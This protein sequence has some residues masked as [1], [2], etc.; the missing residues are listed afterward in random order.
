MPWLFLAASA[1]AA[2][3][4]GA[5]AAL[6]DSVAPLGAAAAVARGVGIAAAAAGLA[7]WLFVPPPPPPLPASGRTDLLEGGKRRRRG[8][9]RFLAPLL[10]LVLLAAFATSFL[11]DEAIEWRASVERN[12]R[13]R[14][15][16]VLRFLKRHPQTG[17]L[18]EALDHLLRD[19]GYVKEAASLPAAVLE[20][21][22]DRVFARVLERVR[23]EPDVAR[24]AEAL[25]EVAALFRDPRH[26]AATRRAY[27]QLVARP[28]LAERA[29]AA[30]PGARA[31]PEGA[32][33]VLL[34]VVEMIERGEDPTLGVVTVPPAGSEDEIYEAAHALARSLAE[35]IPI[36]VRPEAREAE[37]RLA[38]RWRLRDGRL[39][40]AVKLA[41]AASGAPFEAEYEAALAPGAGRVLADA[42]EGDLLPP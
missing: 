17:R 24:A 19:P 2:A 3:L 36:E 8:G 40:V 20:A 38:L 26:V 13:G 23:D 27:V 4:Y 33:A 6:G 1:L 7:T 32:R 42:L 37:R 22:G 21:R 25:V 18:D 34:A 31:L 35:R 30:G 41:G 10:A 39:V 14:R 16:G 28:L 15:E 29:G 5:R 11:L 12:A 9:R